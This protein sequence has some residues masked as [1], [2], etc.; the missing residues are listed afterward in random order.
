MM[1]RILFKFL[2]LGASKAPRRRRREVRRLPSWGERSV[3]PEEFEVAWGKELHTEHEPLGLE[4][5]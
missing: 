2:W 4:A 3:G 5:L 1:A